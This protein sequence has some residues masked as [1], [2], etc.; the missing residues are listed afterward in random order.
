MPIRRSLGARGKTVSTYFT[1]R[2]LA[3]TIEEIGV[4]AG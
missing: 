4:I 3:H 1:H 2:Q